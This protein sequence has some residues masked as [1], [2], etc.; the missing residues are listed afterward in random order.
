MYRFAL[1]IVAVT[2]LVGSVAQAASYETKKGTIEDSIMDT[3]KAPHSYSENNLEVGAY[4]ANA[5]LTG[6][7]LTGANLEYMSDSFFV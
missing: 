3:G 1:L 7:N 2:L 5:N 4:L 6:A